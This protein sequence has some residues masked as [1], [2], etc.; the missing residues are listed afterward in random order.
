MV[1]VGGGGGSRGVAG[2]G[3]R[4]VGWDPRVRGGPPMHHAW[5]PVENGGIFKNGSLFRL[6]F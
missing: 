2:G 4:G 6:Y 1:V 5:G 3:S